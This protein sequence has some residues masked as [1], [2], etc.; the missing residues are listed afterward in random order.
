MGQ[1]WPWK[2]DDDN[3]RVNNGNRP[4]KDW[5]GQPRGRDYHPGRSCQSEAVTV[6][7]AVILAA[8][9]ALAAARAVVAAR[10]HNGGN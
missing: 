1:N 5:R 6:T 4:P 2:D 10:R 7:V 3:G 8:R 9:V